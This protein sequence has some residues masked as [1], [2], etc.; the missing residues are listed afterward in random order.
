LP[1]TADTVLVTEENAH[2]LDPFLRE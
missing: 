2:I 1:A